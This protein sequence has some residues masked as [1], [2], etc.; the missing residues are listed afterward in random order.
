MDCGEIRRLQLRRERRRNMMRSWNENMGIWTGYVQSLR[1]KQSELCI[2]KRFLLKA[3]RKWRQ[4]RWRSTLLPTSSRL[5]GDGWG[6]D[7]GRNYSMVDCL[8]HGFYFAAT[9]MEDKQRGEWFESVSI[10][11]SLPSGCEAS[12]PTL[13]PYEKYKQYV[14]VG[15]WCEGQSLP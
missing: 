15:S 13:Q 1:K 8:G 11:S 3:S 12:V 6:S 4:S 9:V 2:F 14:D 10:F 5:F 7:D